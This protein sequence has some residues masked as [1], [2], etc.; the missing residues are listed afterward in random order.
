MAGAG[1]TTARDGGTVATATIAGLV[2]ASISAVGT[3][4]AFVVVVGSISDCTVYNNF[5]VSPQTFLMI[6]GIIAAV[7]IG[8]SGLAVGAGAGALGGLM[9]QRPWPAGV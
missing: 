9:G 2:G 1:F 6:L 7:I 5:G 4:I 3:I 8:V